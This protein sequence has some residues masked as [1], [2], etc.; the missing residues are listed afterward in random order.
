VT[1]IF[2][3]YTTKLI[4][5][6]N[7]HICFF[8][9]LVNN[10]YCVYSVEHLIE[11]TVNDRLVLIKTLVVQQSNTFY[12]SKQFARDSSARDLDDDLRSVCQF[13]SLAVL[14]AAAILTLT[15]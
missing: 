13:N 14:V 1:C 9:I 8:D 3:S 5:N 7:F 11:D 15:K 12:S 2:P 6:D 10:A 4:V